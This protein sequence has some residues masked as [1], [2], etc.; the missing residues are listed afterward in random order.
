MILAIELNK[1]DWWWWDQ[2]VLFF[3]V[4]VCVCVFDKKSKKKKV[5]CLNLQTEQRLQ[6]QMNK[7]WISPPVWYHYNTTNVCMVVPQSWNC[8][9]EWK[10]LEFDFWSPHNM[11]DDDQ[12]WSTSLSLSHKYM[13]LIYQQH[14]S[15]IHLFTI[16]EH[17]HH[18]HHH[19]CHKFICVT[20][21]FMCFV[22]FLF[23][24]LCIENEIVTIKSLYTTTIN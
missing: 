7:N 4:Y 21:H 2:K 17:H 16:V 3:C 9:I 11:T 19:C 24:D 12:H 15:F 23:F 6:I 1:N 13:H 10:K 18:H 8:K 22:L 20:R 5:G 14:H